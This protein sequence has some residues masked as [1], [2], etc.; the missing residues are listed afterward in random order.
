M[1]VSNNKLNKGQIIIQKSKNDKIYD[2][3][4]KL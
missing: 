4:N 2:L 3:K 1:G